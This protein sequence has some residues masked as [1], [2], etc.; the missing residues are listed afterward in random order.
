MAE[1]EP[2]QTPTETHSYTTHR[3]PLTVVHAR[4]LND[5]RT[6]AHFT[7]KHG[8]PPPNPHSTNGKPTSVVLNMTA[9]T[10]IRRPGTHH[11][12]IPAGTRWS[13][14]LNPPWSTTIPR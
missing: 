13:E 7:S 3:R 10:P 4:T 9:L 11:A 5:I 2:T 8:L 1:D 6:I 12:T 14:V